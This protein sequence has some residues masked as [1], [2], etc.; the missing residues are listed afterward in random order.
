MKNCPIHGRYPFSKVARGK[1]EQDIN[2][3]SEF[4]R[5]EETFE[6]PGKCRKHEL[7]LTDAGSG[8]SARIDARLTFRRCGPHWM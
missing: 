2:Y 1:T 6:L 3:S 7:A 5:L 8:C 4:P